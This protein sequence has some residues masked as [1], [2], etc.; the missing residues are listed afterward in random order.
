MG[1]ASGTEIASLLID[2]CIK[3]V[4]L[5][6]QHEFLLTG[7]RELEKCDWDTVG[8]LLGYYDCTS[9]DPEKILVFGVVNEMYPGYHE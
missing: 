9:S 7:F 2:L 3:Y 5:Q 4:P 6:S 1:W 8:D